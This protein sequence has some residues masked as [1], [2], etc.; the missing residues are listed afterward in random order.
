MVHGG[1][2]VG[3]HYSRPWSKTF[4]NLFHAAALLFGRCG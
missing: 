3:F 4:S 1:V 2:L